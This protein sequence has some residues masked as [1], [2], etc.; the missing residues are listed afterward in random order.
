MDSIIKTQ[1]KFRH[2]LKAKITRRYLMVKYN[3]ELFYFKPFIIYYTLD[4]SYWYRTRQNNK[5]YLTKIKMLL[6]QTKYNEETND[7][8]LTL[9]QENIL[10]KYILLE[11]V[12]K[13]DVINFIKCLAIEQLRFI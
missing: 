5:S 4:N 8:S 3:R 12:Y 6:G 13:I 2:Y 9:D 10:D 11:K 1:N 7:Y